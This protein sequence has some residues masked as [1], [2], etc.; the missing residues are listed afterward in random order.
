VD[1]IKEEQTLLLKES[2]VILLLTK[3]G[4][5]SNPTTDGTEPLVDHPG[6]WPTLSSNSHQN[7]Y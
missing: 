3:I 4:G 6:P 7:I 5:S 2:L 1:F